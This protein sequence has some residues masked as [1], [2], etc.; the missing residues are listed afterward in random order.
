M[1][2][3]GHQHPV[4]PGFLPPGGD[5]VETQNQNRIVESFKGS[6]LPVTILAMLLSIPI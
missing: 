3:G 5:P 2:G 6:S 4:P 1:G